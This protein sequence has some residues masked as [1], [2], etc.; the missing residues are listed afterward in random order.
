MG[1]ETV[2]FHFY[3]NIAKSSVK[4]LHVNLSKI[5]NSVQIFIIEHFVFFALTFF[6]SSDILF[7]FGV[8]SIL[9][10]ILLGTE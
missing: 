9:S 5:K 2:V 7:L 8:E 1:L 4:S 3:N 10:V 6:F